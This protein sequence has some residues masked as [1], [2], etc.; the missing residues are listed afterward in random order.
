MIN[1]LLHLS[2]DKNRVFMTLLVKAEEN[3]PRFEMKQIDE[4]LEENGVS[5]YYKFEPTIVSAL[6]TLNDNKSVLNDDTE[7]VI[8]EKRDAAVTASIEKDK[9]TANLHFT[10]PHGGK[11]ING[12]NILNAMKNEGIIKGIKKKNLQ[13]IFARCLKLKT[14][15]ELT[16]EVAFGKYPINGKDAKLEFYVKDNKERILTPQKKENGKVDMRDLGKMLM[17]ETHQLLAKKIPATEGEN[18]YNVKGEVLASKPGKDLDIKA[19][20][21]SYIDTVTNSQIFA[22]MPG[23]VTIHKDGV[24]V[25]DALCL[26]EVSVATGHVNFTGSVVINNDIAP[27]MKLE[28][29]GSVTVGGSVE[30]AVIRA[31]GDVIIKNGILGRQST[32]EVNLTSII[33]SEGQVFAKFAQYSQ[34]NAKGDIHI[35]HNA[36]HCNTFTR[37]DLIIS[38][39]S[40][41]LGTLN[42]GHHIAYGNVKVVQMGTHSQ[43]PTYVEACAYFHE[44]QTEDENDLLK[45]EEIHL[46]LERIKNLSLKI[47][48]L[49]I[50]KRSTELSHK[51][52]LEKSN[53]L[54]A[55]SKLKLKIQKSKEELDKL[56]K[57]NSI[58]ILKHCHS[59]LFCRIAETQLVVKQE[60]LACKLYSDGEMIHIAPL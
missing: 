5:E 14:G 49:P 42:G 31:G 59:G 13:Q 41:S 12:E 15:E 4:W 20:N 36:S 16:I 19:Y 54:K 24:E 58:Q 10:G 55:H 44:M 27:G 23:I 6:A 47:L 22:E 33:N 51:L 1:E 38:D 50:E 7:M 37:G 3:I 46:N 18:G 8:A 53:Q 39:N 11:P 40:G 45:L 29:S 26:N 2:E 17:V 32:E 52:S 57:E 9:M 21:G 25:L 43:T 35:S 34:I 30:S 28:A 56:L 60:H 48:Q